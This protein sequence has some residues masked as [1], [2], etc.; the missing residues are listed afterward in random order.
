LPNKN[1][2][3]FFLPLLSFYAFMLLALCLKSIKK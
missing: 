1:K 2:N 3:I